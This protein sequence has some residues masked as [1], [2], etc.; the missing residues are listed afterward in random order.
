MN[1]TPLK[2]K[3]SRELSAANKLYLLLS[4]LPLWGSVYAV[5]CVSVNSVGVDYVAKN[6]TF[7]LTWANC[8]NVTHLNKAWVFVDWQQVTDPNTTG[9]WTRATI[10]GAATVTNGTY[11]AGNATGFYVTG[12]NGQSATVT[13]K[14]SNAPAKFNWCAVAT[15]YPP[16]VAI[17]N[18]GTY[19]LRGTAPF[20]L[21]GS[22]TVNSKT[23]IG[24]TI[25]TI[26]DATGCPG[27]ACGNRDVNVGA[28]GCCLS[29][30]TLVGDYCRDLVADG[31]STYVAC[32]NEETKKTLE[33]KAETTGINGH[34][35]PA[36]WRE[37]YASEARCMFNAKITVDSWVPLINA[38]TRDSN[39]TGTQCAMLLGMASYRGSCSY[40]SGK[41]YGFLWSATCSK[42]FPQ[43]VR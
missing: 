2:T 37:P 20:L 21:N 31:A 23:Y 39:C 32:I 29:G 38:T 9:A 33:V 35:C 22:I 13:V 28:G 5:N 30:L 40:T 3:H 6:V 16:N 8:D 14:L 15:D 26:T 42:Y 12:V 43:C 11:T 19:T 17:F 36:G 10:S 1:R 4:L 25:S 7:V 18:N 24:E 34:S 41:I 27:I